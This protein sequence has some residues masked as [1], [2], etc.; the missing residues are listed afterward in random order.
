MSG[1]E[2]DDD[3][4]DDSDDDVIPATKDFDEFHVDLC[5]GCSTSLPLVNDSSS[6]I[7]TALKNDPFMKKFFIGFNRNLLRPKNISFAGFAELLMK[8]HLL[9]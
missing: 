7:F 1:D 5:Q 3:D 4:F 9:V 8:G 6:R 2:D